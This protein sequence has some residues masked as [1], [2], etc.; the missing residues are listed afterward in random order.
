MADQTRKPTAQ[1]LEM[2]NSSSRG[3]Q[4]RQAQ[5]RTA[6]T[7]A[8]SGLVP[9]LEGSATAQ[10]G[11][12][13]DPE[14][15]G[16]MLV[17]GFTW[18]FSDE[19]TASLR[20]AIQKGIRGD[21]R[22]FGEIYKETI[23]GLEDTRRQW[24]AEHTG[25][26]IGLNVAGSLPTA[27]GVKT[28]LTKAG[29]K[30]LPLLPKTLPSLGVF[31]E[32][33]TRAVPAASVLATEG[34]VMGA[35][36][37]QSGES[38][39]DAAIDG[40]M[41][42]LMFGT[43]MR[44]AGSTWRAASNR[45][46][47]QELG[48]GPDFIP[49]PMADQGGTLG[50][51]YNKIVGK[52]FYGAN[53]VK[54]QINRWRVPLAKN[55]EEESAA[56]DNIRTINSLEQTT[57]QQLKTAKDELASTANEKIA[58]ITEE[59]VAAAEREA[60]RIGSINAARVTRLEDGINMRER[61][62]RNDAVARSAPAGLGQGEVQKIISESSSMNEAADKLRAAW[63]EHGYSYLK[64]NADGSERIFN[65]SPSTIMD[66][67]T[68]E[69]PEDSATFSLLFG[70]Q[71]GKARKL[72]EE[73]LA[74]SVSPDGK[75][76]GE[77]FSQLRSKLGTMVGNLM[78]Q[79]G[80]QAQQGYVLNQMLHTIKKQIRDQLPEAEQKLLDADGE[81]WNTMLILSKSV[82]KA[83]QTGGR[84]G[85]FTPSEW[86]SSAGGVNPRK[87]ERG[88]AILQTEAN[89]LDDIQKRT[90]QIISSVGEHQK[91]RMAQGN[92]RRARL[93]Q[94]E[95]ARLRQAQQQAMGET[96]GAVSASSAQKAADFAQRAQSLEASRK[97]LDALDAMLTKDSGGK[98]A[99]NLGVMA[100]IGLTGNMFGLGTYLAGGALAGTQS[101]QRALAGQTAV[102]GGMRAVQGA[103]PW[104]GVSR[105]AE[106]ENVRQDQ[107]TLD[108]SEVL[109]V[110]RVG[111][112]SSQAAAY[113]R[114]ES[115]G[116]IEVLK[117]R[118]K[119]AYDILKEAY[120]QENR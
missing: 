26:S 115:S 53:L 83:S 19:I 96:T 113:R 106:R 93:L 42:N 47:S 11:W 118:N 107:A 85:A 67:I 32:T 20:G 75:I 90:A 39:Q 18:G 41:T 84:R 120:D 38:M 48:S 68:K 35:G 61:F 109:T 65:V 79:G 1:E 13:E 30:V 34:A 94:Q 40:A 56:L 60:E 101:F 82:L 73:Y 108:N 76:T 22:P 16:R 14:M 8:P 71:P 36:Y 52:T 89:A 54:Q 98:N 81:A 88:R 9:L 29:Q 4:N 58:G 44:A 64:K 51:T 72:I 17:D 49:L 117:T 97:Q 63:N 24:E 74:E 43:A 37:A 31:G 23:Y 12:W 10:D 92:R 95:T 77:A 103:V 62:F 7:P 3:S 86:L 116:Q 28:L 112:K 102:Q 46:V 119:K 110:A 2:L 104:N 57:S 21:E 59:S 105:A 25:A 6:G 114:L 50:E 66:D 91:T 5:N 78:E 55:V 15:V 100:A 33:V 27:G 111:N 69:F 70:S 87:L 45:R 80:E 99:G